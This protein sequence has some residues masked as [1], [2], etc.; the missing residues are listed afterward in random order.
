MHENRKDNPSP[1]AT[2]C[3]VLRTD[4]SER[5]SS[6]QPNSFLEFLFQ[7]NSEKTSVSSCPVGTQDA[8]SLEEVARHAQT[9]QPDQRFPLDVH[10]QISSIPRGSYTPHHQQEISTENW[11]YPSE[12]QLFNAM[13]KKG[14]ANIPEESI[15]IVLTIHNS[16]NER[17]WKQ[18]QKWEGSAD[19]ILTKFHGRPG[20][21]TPKAM[22]LSTLLG[23]DPPFDRHDWYVGNGK[24]LQRYVIDYYYL[25]PPQP[26]LPPIPYVDARPALDDLRSVY[27]R[28]RNF[29]E[30]AFP[31]IASFLKSRN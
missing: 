23:Y 20:D 1:T 21:L 6:K 7:K 25:P 30:F 24:Y 5:S 27:L 15:P 12:Q 10:R 17:T 26:D 4:S 22:A 3:P 9:P 14:W 29:L 18:I 11:V 8:A 28:T 13:R 2:S 19:I 16:I 31:G